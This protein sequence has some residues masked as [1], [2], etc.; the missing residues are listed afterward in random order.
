M[1]PIKSEIINFLYATIDVLENTENID[2]LLIGV[3]MF[4]EDGPEL[5]VP[6]GCGSFAEEQLNENSIEIQEYSN[7]EN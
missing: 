2:N 3:V 7:I 6:Q 5:M 1:K 4:T